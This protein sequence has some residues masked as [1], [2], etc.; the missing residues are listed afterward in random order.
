V[1]KRVVKGDGRLI[2][3]SLGSFGTIDNGKRASRHVFSGP[4]APKSLDTRRLRVTFPGIDLRHSSIR[5]K[6]NGLKRGGERCTTV[7]QDPAVISSDSAY[8]PARC[9]AGKIVSGQRAK[10]LIDSA[11]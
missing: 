9:L 8:P 7:V 10:S 4:F 3:P 2:E 6:E 5:A 1:W 11:F